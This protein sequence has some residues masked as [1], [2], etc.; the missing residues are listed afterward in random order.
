MRWSLYIQATREPRRPLPA[1]AGDHGYKWILCNVKGRFR[2]AGIPEPGVCC[3][4]DLST[5]HEAG[6]IN[7]HSRWGADGAVCNVLTTHHARLDPYSETRYIEYVP[8]TLPT[9]WPWR[10]SFRFDYMYLI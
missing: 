3:A 7:I 9:G 10:F 1:K 6:I 5:P 4:L 8:K 2:D